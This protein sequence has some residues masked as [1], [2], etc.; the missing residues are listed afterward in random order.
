M[1]LSNMWVQSLD[2]ILLRSSDITVVEVSEADTWGVSG[3]CAVRVYSSLR[4]HGVTIAVAKTRTAA[5][6]IRDSL[7]AVM[8]EEP[9]KAMVVRSGDKGFNVEQLA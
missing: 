2:G 8:C 7:A 3:V 1:S 4:P 9:V 5:D 6:V